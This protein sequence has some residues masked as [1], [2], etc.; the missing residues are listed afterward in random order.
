MEL[1]K[2]EMFR[3]AVREPSGF[4]ADATLRP[5]EV[6]ED[7]EATLYHQHWRV[8]DAQIFGKK[9]PSELDPGIVCERRYAL[10]WLV[11]WGSD[12]DDV[13]TDT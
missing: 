4:L 7:G 1:R 3:R 13:P 5:S 12:W 8:R 6:L 11:G 2:N 10:S 9:M